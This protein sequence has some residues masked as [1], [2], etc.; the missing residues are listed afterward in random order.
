[1]KNFLPKACETSISTESGV[2]TLRTTYGAKRIATALI[3]PNTVNKYRWIKAAYVHH[4][5]NS[6]AW[7]QHDALVAEFLRTPGGG[8]FYTVPE[9]WIR[10][11]TLT[12]AQK[13]YVL[14]QLKM[15]VG[16]L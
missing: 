4:A 7:K 6:M 11:R 9:I 10:D 8:A 3:G 12:P 13:K 2:C 1:M 16:L 15:G 5:T 14:K